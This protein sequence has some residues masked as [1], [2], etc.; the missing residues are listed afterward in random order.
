MRLGWVLQSFRGLQYAETTFDHRTSLFP[1]FYVVSWSEKL[2]Y[3][4]TLC[5]DGHQTLLSPD[6]MSSLL[7]LLDALS[8]HI[9]LPT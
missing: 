1:L 9:H 4:C 6:A 5:C 3:H 8:K 7:R 2:Q